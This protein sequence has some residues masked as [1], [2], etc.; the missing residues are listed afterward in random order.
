MLPSRLRNCTC[1]PPAPSPC[2]LF[3]SHPVLL[4]QIVEFGIVGV[5]K[6]VR[7][8]CSA[9]SSVILLVQFLRQ[10]A[11]TTNPYSFI[12]ER[13]GKFHMMIHFIHFNS[14]V[15]QTG[16]VTDLNLVQ[17]LHTEGFTYFVLMG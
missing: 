14:Y 2:S 5:I 13:V 7:C 10:L 17:T 11:A 3:T 4:E 16:C 9:A 12:H 6:C 15:I 8:T 1:S